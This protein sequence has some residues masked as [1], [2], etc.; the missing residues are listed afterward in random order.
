MTHCHVTVLQL[1]LQL[2]KRVRRRELYAYIGETSSSSSGSSSNGSSSAAVSS[3]HTCETV[4]QGV[5][6]HATAASTGA[7]ALTAADLLVC[8]VKISYGKG[9]Y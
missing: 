2:I 5:L 4:R 9:Q 3:A 1:L 8:S 6:S 7:D